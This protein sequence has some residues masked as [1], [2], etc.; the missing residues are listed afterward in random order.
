[1]AVNTNNKKVPSNYSD[2]GQYIRQIAQVLNRT[3]DGKTNNVGEIVVNGSSP[4]TFQNT[5]V[6]VNSVILLA[7]QSQTGMTHHFYAIAGD[8]EFTVYFTGTVSSETIK[9][10]VV[11]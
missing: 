10:V 11:S 5:L 3:V 4:Q 7:P 1:M 9:Y 6:N 8:K 2:A